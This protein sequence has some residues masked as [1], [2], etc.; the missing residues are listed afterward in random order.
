[1]ETVRFATALLGRPQATPGGKRILDNLGDITWLG[2]NDDALDLRLLVPESITSEVIQWFSNADTSLREHSEGAWR[3][4][5]EELLE[6]TPLLSSLN[7]MDHVSPLQYVGRFQ[8]EAWSTNPEINATSP[9]VYTFETYRATLSEEAT[10]VLEQ[11]ISQQHPPMALVKSGKRWKALS[12]KVGNVRT[13]HHTVF[14]KMFSLCLATTNQ[15]RRT[16]MA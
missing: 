4:L 8:T 11:Q 13:K 10:Q 16:T 9:T 3:E 14:R 6:E 1:M 7:L 5:R 2:K 15:S 12:L